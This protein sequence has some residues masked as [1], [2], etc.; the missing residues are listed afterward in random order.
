MSR[1]EV[2][3]LLTKLI[4]EEILIKFKLT[5]TTHKKEIDLVYSIAL[6][7]Q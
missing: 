6:R 3:I 4:D 1:S 2:H 5:L 7:K